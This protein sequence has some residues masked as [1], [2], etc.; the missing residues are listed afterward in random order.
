M[1]KL[2]VRRERLDTMPNAKRLHH[3]ILGIYVTLSQL[4]SCS[5]DIVQTDFPS[6]VT[7]FTEILKP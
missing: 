2:N 4:H 5:I 6:L 7:Y 3:R 1:L